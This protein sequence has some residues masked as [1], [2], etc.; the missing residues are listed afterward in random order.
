MYVHVVRKEAEPCR[1]STVMLQPFV[2]LSVKKTLL[3]QSSAPSARDLLPGASRPHEGRPA[4][5]L[6][7]PQILGQGFGAGFMRCEQP[8]PGK[9]PNRSPSV[10]VGMLLVGTQGANLS[11]GT[12]R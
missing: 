2:L 9:N 1:N 3:V 6:S 12:G 5:M 10:M 4:A 7:P 8:E 11:C